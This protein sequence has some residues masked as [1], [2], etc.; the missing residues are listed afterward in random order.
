MKLVLLLNNNL[1]FLLLK[2]NKYKYIIIYNKSTNIYIKY[3]FNLSVDVF[4]FKN[5]NYITV[6]LNYFYF[7]TKN[8]TNDLLNKQVE[9]IDFYFVKKIV[10][11]GKGF[12]I[13]KFKNKTLSLF[14]N[15]SHI[16]FIKWGCISIKKLKKTKIV[17]C[18]SNHQ[19]INSCTRSIVNSRPLNV[20]TK[21]GLRLSRQLVFKKVGKKTT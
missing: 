6:R 4:F 19:S 1:N 12:K 15:K 7:S 14:F 8:I 3:K 18:S 10:F 13:K 9:S 20:F 17:V 2:K 21:K 5:L 16:N 11:F